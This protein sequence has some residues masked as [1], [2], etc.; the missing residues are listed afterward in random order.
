MIKPASL[1]GPR[2]DAGQEEECGIGGTGGNGGGGLDALV[3]KMA[4][5]RGE[6][7]HKVAGQTH[8]NPTHNISRLCVQGRRRVSGEG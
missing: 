2:A 5:S 4:G 6:A 7:T 3:A 1:Q 8:Q